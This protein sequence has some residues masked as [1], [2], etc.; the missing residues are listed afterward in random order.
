MNQALN[1]LAHFR[2]NLVEAKATLR[3]AKDGYETAR[4]IAELTAIERL[5][6]S[7]GK[8]EAE[9]ARNL[10]VELL[11]DDTHSQALAHLRECERQ[12]DQL[13]ACIA[14]EED[15]IR[16]AELAA[17]ERLAEALMGKR[18]DDSIADQVMA[19]API[20]G[21]SADDVA[22]QQHMGTQERHHPDD[23]YIDTDN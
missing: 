12:V 7:A 22:W 21:Q 1:D 6:G 10:T 15:A 13:N 18:A 11:H 19:I 2:M 16:V 14:V 8:N 4:A 23:W 20:F 3:A 9:R 17:R 5:N